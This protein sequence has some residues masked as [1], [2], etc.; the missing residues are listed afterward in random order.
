M[1]TF[2]IK[3]LWVSIL[4]LN[5]L[6]CLVVAYS[7]YEKVKDLKAWQLTKATV[8]S[9]TI[10][11]ER[12]S[13]GTAYC[14]DVNVEFVLSGV[15]HGSTL[16]ISQ[17]PCNLS[18]LAANKTASAYSIGNAIDVYVNPSKPSEVRLATYSLSWIF[19]LTSI[20]GALS[21]IAAFV[22]P[23]MRANPAV[24]RVAPQAARPLP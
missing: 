19:Y 20:V 18:S 5:S 7:D 10:K 24:K 16:Q 23:F 11:Q 17:A 9:A 15:Q 2:L 4:L 22:L 14:P 13:K 21:L 1:K 3:T 12:R 6:L 8:V